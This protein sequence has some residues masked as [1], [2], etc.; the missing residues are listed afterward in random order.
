[1]FP[2]HTPE[3]VELAFSVCVKTLTVVRLWLRLSP[4]ILTDAASLTFCGSPPA[5]L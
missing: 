3:N 5:C 4:L 2:L 1:M